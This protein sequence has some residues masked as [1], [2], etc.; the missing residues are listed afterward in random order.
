MKTFSLKHE[1]KI[2]RGAL[3]CIFQM[4]PVQLKERLNEGIKFN[5]TAKK[6]FISSDFYMVENLSITVYA[7]PVLM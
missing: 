4:F 5:T 1:P 7:F 6:N 3:E 2:L